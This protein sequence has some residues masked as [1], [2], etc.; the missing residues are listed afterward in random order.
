MLA[1]HISP[2]ETV[3]LRVE[4]GQQTVGSGRVAVI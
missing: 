4:D 2:G 1:A 3:Q